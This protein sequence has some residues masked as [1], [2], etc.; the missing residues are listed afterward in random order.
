MANAEQATEAQQKLL[1]ELHAY[2]YSRYEDEDTDGWDYVTECY[3]DA[4]VIEAIGNATTLAAAKRN[5]AR[6]FHLALSNEQHMEARSCIDPQPT[7]AELLAEWKADDD[8]ATDQQHPDDVYDHEHWRNVEY[9]LD[10]FAQTL[11]CPPEMAAEIVQ[12]GR[13]MVAGKFDA[14]GKTFTPDGRNRIDYRRFYAAL[15]ALRVRQVAITSRT[16]RSRWA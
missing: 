10:D 6:K 14:T 1:D 13:D 16:G 9:D 2:C 8:I 3:E 15:E 5:V 11:D 4:E 7:E 12:L